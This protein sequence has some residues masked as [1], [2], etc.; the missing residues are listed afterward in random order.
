MHKINNPFLEI[1]GYQCFG[2]APDNPSGLQMEFFKD[3]DQ[4][5]SFWE[6]REHLQGYGNI[7]HGGIQSTL[8]D[9][10]ASWVIFIM[11]RTAGVTRGMNVRYLKPVNVTRGMLELRGHIVKTEGN[12]VTVLVSLAYKDSGDIL[13]EADVEYF[14]FPEKMA[15][16]K[17]Y[18]PEYEKFGLPEEET[19]TRV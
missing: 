15:R 4:I 14:T 11:C 9:E 12:L 6:S 13:A 5:V 1:E 8:M 18:F 16:R 19:V 3:G 2:C 10:L 17:L 7:L